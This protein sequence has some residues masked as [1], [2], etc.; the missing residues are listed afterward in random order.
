[1]HQAKKDIDILLEELEKLTAEYEVKK[2]EYRN[3]LAGLGGE[4]E[5]PSEGS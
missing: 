4:W 1:M 3:R 2:A 5:G